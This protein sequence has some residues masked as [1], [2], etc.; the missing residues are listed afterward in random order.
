VAR[1]VFRRAFV[2][3]STAALA[4][5]LAP[6]VEAVPRPLAGDSVTKGPT[7]APDPPGAE[8]WAQRYD[9]PA[10]S[11]D[12]ATSMG[13]SPD[14]AIVY[15]TGSSYECCPEPEIA[16]YA[17]IAYEASTGAQRWVA[18]Y[19]GIEPNSYDD[20]YSLGLSPDG[21]K[22]YVTGGS[23]G[24][25]ATV[26]YD[27]QKGTELWAARFQLAT[28]SV[29]CDAAYS[30]GVSPDGAAVYVTGGIRADFATIAYDASTGNQRWAARYDGPAH[31]T[32]TAHSL[33]VAPDGTRVYVTGESY[34]AGPSPSKSYV[35][36]AY[37]AST[38]ITLWTR[39]TGGTLWAEDIP[40]SVKVHPGGA[41]VFVTGSSRRAPSFTSDYLTICY[42]A[43]TGAQVW[44][45]RFD[46]PAHG[47]DV[48]HSVAVNAAGTAVYVTGSGSFGGYYADYATISY[49]AHTGAQRW[50]A[51]YDGPA[52]QDDQATSLDLDSESALLFVT[53]Q[54]QGDYATVGYDGFNGAQMWVARYD[55]PAHS[56]D[57]AHSLIVSPDDARLFVTGSSFGTG[58][59]DYA[60]VAYSTR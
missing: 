2:V 29:C 18:R 55:G 41:L 46:G 3:C 42:D 57:R 14:G 48:A 36:I 25:F 6:G 28:H 20:A 13:A 40:A 24:A 60:T 31:S 10:G 39:R 11:H 59:W 49:D 34:G 32:D 58:G 23:G 26:A 43:V 19:E 44:S 53:G 30:L 9:G 1:S 5:S 37:A 45:A 51:H 16:D 7:P 22:V 21:S 12:Y 52:Q 35:T 50:F 17:T 47:W 4:S 38:G 27:A 54:S 56:D 33:A 8:L 15:V